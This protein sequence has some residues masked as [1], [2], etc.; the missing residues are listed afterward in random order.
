[1][2]CHF[3]VEIQNIR[4]NKPF[5]WHW[6]FLQESI[7]RRGK[8]VSWHCHSAVRS[9]SKKQQTMFDTLGF[10]LRSYTKAQRHPFSWHDIFC[11]EIQHIRHNKPFSCHWKFA[12]RANA[13]TR[14]TIFVTLPFCAKIQVKDATNQ[15]RDSGA[16]LKDPIQKHSDTHF[17]DMSFLRRD[18]IYKT[19][20]TIFVTLDFCSKVAI[21][22]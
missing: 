16:L 4:H 1:M 18:P 20:Q 7:Q 17:R 22:R 15:S 2:T 5:S 11:A 21:L 13:K 3:C 10:A 19:Q 14:Q 12:L 6:D 9:N 8:P